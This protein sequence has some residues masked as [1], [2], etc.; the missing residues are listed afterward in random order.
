MTKL[1]EALSKISGEIV[2]EN[3]L[4]EEGLDGSEDSH[5]FRVT[6]VL[7]SRLDWIAEIMQHDRPGDEESQD[8][9]QMVKQVLYAIESNQ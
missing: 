3:W 6:D 1:E 2:W 8:T 9:I 7:T 4:V 5:Y